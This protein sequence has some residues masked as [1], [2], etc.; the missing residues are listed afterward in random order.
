MDIVLLFGEV[1]FVSHKKILDGIVEAAEKDGHNLFLFTCE[2][3]RYQEYSQ[4][5]AGEYRIFGLPELEKYDGII[6]DFDTIH[7]PKT[8]ALLQERIAETKVPCVSI[9]VGI[10]NASIV[11]LEN[12]NGIFHMVEH[13]VHVHG[14]KDIKYISGP[15]YNPDARERRQAFLEAMQ[16]ME[17]E[18]D[19]ESVI[20]GDF[21]SESGQ[22]L[23]REYIESGQEMP[24]AFVVANDY[25]AIAVI[26]GLRQAGYRV[27]EDV[28]VTG[29]DNI[30]LAECVQPQLTTVDRREYEAGLMAYRKLMERIDGGEAKREIIVGRPVYS[31][32]CGCNAG[33]EAEHQLVHICS[34]LVEQH[35]FMDNNLAILKNTAVEFFNIESFDDFFSYMHRYIEELDLE[36]FYLCLCGSREDYYHEIEMMASGKEPERDMTVFSDTVHCPLAYE[37]G[38]WTSYSTFPKG[39]LLPPGCR[40]K[41][42]GSYYIIMPVHQ[43]ETCIGYCVVGNYRNLTEGRFLQ[44]LVLNI[45]YAVGN[46]RKQDIMRTML[47][48]INQKWMYDELTGIYNRSGLWKQAE[49]FTTKARKEQ[50]LLAVLFFDLDGLKAVNDLNGHEA[51]DRYIRS[52]AD[53]L[54]ICRNEEDILVRYGGDEYI[55]VTAVYSQME[56]E[57]YIDR[58]QRRVKTFNEGGCEYPLS[59]S[60]GYSMEN[61][62]RKIE[63]Q[64][65]IEEADQEM[66]KEKRKKKE[67]ARKT[68]LVP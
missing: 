5:H 9:N 38:E 45:D 10:V 17:L 22:N 51:G 60:I 61:D 24:D 64:G 14:A 29:Y 48:R 16:Q 1:G 20:Y 46:I 54:R 63:L 41:S 18:A 23:I 56:I 58:I 12:C 55:I 25:M 26:N 30:D 19:E 59:V 67:Y 21:S 13:L 28:I 2:G 27:P 32:S 6:V 31:C 39:D 34:N 50:R 11:V 43:D 37:K 49:G 33:R 65:L 52:M 42:R 7:E 4:Y 36:Y 15:M 40:E 35:I 44:H 66:Y 57:K 47:A 3:W 53:I 68:I 62:V 8:N